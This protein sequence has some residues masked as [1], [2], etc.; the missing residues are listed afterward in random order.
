M[1]V[2]GRLSQ[3]V[4]LSDTLA[5]GTGDTLKLSLTATENGKAR[6]P[7]QA[8]IVLKE[9]E[10]GLEAPF[11]LTLKDNGKGVVEIVRLPLSSAKIDGDV[12]ADAY[13]L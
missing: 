11:A 3:G 6:R 9:E 12:K 1:V 7:H 8:F 5:L 2:V 4:A 13:G 10:T